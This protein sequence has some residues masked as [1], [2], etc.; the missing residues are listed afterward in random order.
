MD[1]PLS[2]SS[3]DS[4]NSKQFVMVIF[5][6]PRRW[7]AISAITR[8]LERCCSVWKSEKYSFPFNFSLNFVPMIRFCEGCG[9]SYDN[10]KYLEEADYHLIMN[11][12]LSLLAKLTIF[13]HHHRKWKKQAVRFKGYLKLRKALYS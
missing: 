7:R 3:V 8:E 9:F 2:I 12:D 13:R 5:S 4:L 6:A 1:V 11:N 10:L